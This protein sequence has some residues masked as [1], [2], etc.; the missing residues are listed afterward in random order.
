[1]FSRQLVQLRWTLKTFDH[2]VQRLADV[3]PGGRTREVGVLLGES[4]HDQILVSPRTRMVKVNANVEAYML[5]E[6]V[7]CGFFK[8]ASDVEP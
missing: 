1:M 3:V 7:G 6:A 2:V 5:G 4:E 8:N